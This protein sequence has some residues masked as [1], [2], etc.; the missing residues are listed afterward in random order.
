MFLM[1]LNKALKPLYLEL[2]VKAAE[3]NGIVAQEEKNMLKAYGQEMDIEPI[4]STNKTID[5]VLS[6][7][8]SLSS[9]ANDLRIIIFEILGLLQSDSV[10]DE[11]EQEFVERIASAFGISS[12]LCAEMKDL[13]RDYSLLYN[14]I[15]KLV[16]E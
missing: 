2:A 11:K 8:T 1:S 9:S 10:F 13:L 15:C 16:L 3:A 12:T 6:T 4:Y 7:I 14:R 5:E